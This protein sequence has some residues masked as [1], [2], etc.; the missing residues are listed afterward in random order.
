MLHQPQNALHAH[1]HH[2]SLSTDGLCVIL[3]NCHNTHAARAISLRQNPTIPKRWA[4]SL[5][6][7][8]IAVR[9]QQPRWT[10]P[11]LITHLTA[12]ND[13]KFVMFI[14]ISVHISWWNKSI[15]SCHPRSSILFQVSCSW[16]VMRRSG[17]TL[18]VIWFAKNLLLLADIVC[19]SS[20]LEWS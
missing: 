9:S 4:A 15:S 8:I 18:C 2:L 7:G 14:A 3:L 13:K 16:R 19:K 5:A 20:G 6:L 17:R 11:P 12:F 1:I 10:S